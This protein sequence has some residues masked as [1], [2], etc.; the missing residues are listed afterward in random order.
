MAARA[1]GPRAI[2]LL[3]DEF[4]VANAETSAVRE[5]AHRFIEQQVRDGDRVV[6]LKPLDSLPA[7]HLTAHRNRMHD[8]INV[9][10]GRRGNYEPRSP[11]KEQT[12]ESPAL[13]E[14][15]RAQIVLSGLRALASRLGG[16]PG[17][18]G[19]ILIS[20]GFTRDARLAN[21]RVLP[22]ASAVER[23]ANRSDVPVFALDPVTG[24]S[25]DP[26][27]MTLTQLA[28]QTGGFFESGG[29]IATALR[30]ASAELD[31]GYVLTFRTPQ[32]P[33]GRFHSVTVQST[34]RHT[35][36]RSRAG[37]FAASAQRPSG[38]RARYGLASDHAI[39]APKPL[40]RCLVRRHSL[41]QRG[42]AGGG[43]LGARAPIR[44]D[45]GGGRAR[46]AHRHTAKRNGP[47]QG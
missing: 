10:D 45:G 23:F 33:D 37:T 25:D 31:G 14:A 21:A 34:R 47:L 41:R 38:V 6:V 30:R 35:T 12:S 4:H 22:G 13:A 1:P 28:A 5:A 42:G 26:G 9:F 27:E 19:I 11:L 39:A 46:D 17:R 2:A 7:I 20:E 15:S 8:A 3:L 43:D 40:H 29:D 16:E 36:A 44:P 24:P 32:G 18:A